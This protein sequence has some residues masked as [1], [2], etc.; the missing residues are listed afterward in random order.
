MGM[1]AAVSLDDEFITVSV[2]L[3]ISTRVTKHRGSSRRNRHTDAELTLRQDCSFF[4]LR[5]TEGR[6]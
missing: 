5:R 3:P 4:D 2:I 1:F 6:C